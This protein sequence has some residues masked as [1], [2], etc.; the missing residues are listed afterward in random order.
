L[1]IFLKA[2][3]A[4]AAMIKDGPRIVN[5]NPNSAL[6]CFEFGDKDNLWQ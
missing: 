1:N 3:E 2:F 6:R 5:L 4:G